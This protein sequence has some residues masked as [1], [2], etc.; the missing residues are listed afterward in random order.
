M[1]TALH[2]LKPKSA[3]G[4][5][6]LNNKVL[7]NLGKYGKHFL[8]SLFNK[9]FLENDI[10]KGWK[11]AK[12]KM[13]PKKTHDSHNINSYRPISLTNA[14]IKLLE[15]LIKARLVYFLEKNKL[16]SKFQSGFREQR[17][18]MDNIFY[19]TQKCLLAFQ[20]KEKMGG[21]VFDIE[22][23]FDKIWHEGLLKKMHD[24][25]IPNKIAKWIK[26][27]LTDRAF[28]V[29]NDGKDSQL[30]D[31]KTGVP[32]GSILSPILFSIF[33]NDIPLEL[34]NYEKLGGALYADD[35]FSFYSDTNL[36]RIQIVLQKY[37]NKLE[38]WLK[39]WRHKAPINARTIYIRQVSQGKNLIYKFSAKE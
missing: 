15:R 3:S 4:P 6:N 36:N 24:M 9:S 11:I 23:A 17:C 30:F 35:L 32:Q 25:K 2:S 12:M 27:F 10:P 37:L 39:K 22:K 14:I 16:L 28:Y 5:D 21:I 8:L 29:S 13:L 19:F 33:I 18:P 26:N 7:K 31:I 38:Q 20:K 34:E 1:D